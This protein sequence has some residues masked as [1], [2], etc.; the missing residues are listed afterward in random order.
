MYGPEMPSFLAV[1]TFAPIYL[2]P[3]W[4]LAVVIYSMQ[5]VSKTT[6]DDVLDH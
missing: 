1:I 2:P 3:L 4:S 6:F 5:L